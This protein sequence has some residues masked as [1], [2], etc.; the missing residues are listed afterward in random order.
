MESRERRWKGEL[1]QFPLFG[2]KWYQERRGWWP[3]G[4]P[5]KRLRRGSWPAVL[6][7]TAAVRPP[8]PSGQGSSLRER[9]WEVELQAKACQGA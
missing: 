7:S 8:A 6:S 5:D 4:S 2:A 1:L 9:D 3:A